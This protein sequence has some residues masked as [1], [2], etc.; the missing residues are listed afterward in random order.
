MRGAAGDQHPDADR[1]AGDHAHE[2]V[3]ADLLSGRTAQHRPAG[4]EQ[5]DRR[6]QN[7]DAPSEQPRPL[8]VAAGEL[9]RQRDVRHLEQAERRG[10]AEE[11]EQNADRA[12]RRPPG[13]RHGERRR[14]ED[15]QRQGADHH[16][17]ATRSGAGQLPV[18]CGADQRVDDD[19]PHLR[20]GDDQPGGEGRDAEIVR[21]VVGE[22]ETG[23]G[24]V[25]AGADGA[26]RIRDDRARRQAGRG[27]FGSSTVAHRASVSASSDG[28]GDR[29]SDQRQLAQL[30][31]DVVVRRLH[32]VGGIRVDHDGDV[33]AA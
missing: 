20:G 8:V 17:P 13:R 5:Q 28:L 22:D 10:G 31:G 21:E 30:R 3:S 33:R 24:C 4:A 14:E 32:V 7:D 1:D 19:V 9:C 25:P 29:T 11:R 12:R 27:S 26:D 15:R 6:G 18:R 23:E 16:E 2:Q